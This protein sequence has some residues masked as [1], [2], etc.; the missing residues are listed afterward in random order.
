MAT[1]SVSMYS[2]APFPKEL[3]VDFELPYDPYYV[4]KNGDS[5]SEA[6]ATSRDL[7]AKIGVV[8][9]RDHAHNQGIMLQPKKIFEGKIP[10]VP[11]G[12]VWVP[13]EPLVVWGF[14]CETTY[15]HIKLL[16]WPAA[17]DAT[18]IP[19]IEKYKKKWGDTKKWLKWNDKKEVLKIT[20]GTVSCT[21]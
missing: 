21:L 11:I 10:E 5:L 16:D 14:M 19:S 20:P 9:Y 1:R 12:E 17:K 2:L 18:E 4:G 13:K 7:L 3:R 6:A 15:P 8:F